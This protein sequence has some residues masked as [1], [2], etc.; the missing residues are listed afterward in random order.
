MII[1]SLVRLYDQLV[2]AGDDSVAPRGYSRQLISFRVVLNKNG[3]LHDIE[4]VVVQTAR[5]IKKKVKGQVVT[6]T[7]YDERPKPMLVPGQ[8]KPSGSG[9]NPCFLWDNAAY[10]LGFKAEDPK[11]ERTKEAFKAFRDRHLALADKIKDDGFKAVCAFLKQW[12]PSDCRGF[13]Q[14]SEITANFGVF[15]LRA[16]SRPIHDRPTVRAW[17]ARNGVETDDGSDQSEASAESLSS[18]TR[19]PIARLHEPRIKPVAGAQSSGA[20]IVSFN[21][22]AFESYG[23][24]QGENAP[25]GT[26]DAFKY[27]TALNRLVSDER[28]RVRMSGD[29]YV[30]WSEGDSKA[31]ADLSLYFSSML[32]DASNPKDDVTL[33]RLQG[34]MQ[35]AAEGGRV[36]DFGDPLRPFYVLGLSPNMAR[37]SIRLWMPS[38]VGEMVKKLA[39]L[40]TDLA[41]GRDF[42]SLVPVELRKDRRSSYMVRAQ[43]ERPVSSSMRRTIASLTRLND[44][45]EPDWDEFDKSGKYNRIQESFLRAGL[46]DAPFPLSALTAAV[47]KMGREGRVEVGRL[48]LVK[49]VL[50]RNG[51]FQ[52]DEYLNKRHSNPAY[53]CGRMLAVI[54]RAQAK[55]IGNTNSTITRSN[56]GAAMTAPGLTIPRLAGLAVRAYFPKIGGARRKFIEDELGALHAQLKDRFPRVLDQY[57]QGF[58]LLGYFQE[59]LWLQATW[60]PLAQLKLRTK[61]HEWVRSK[62]ELAVANCL[63]DMGIR[64][65]YEPQ[66]FLKR[67]RERWPDFVIP[68]SQPADEVYIEYLG[69]GG[70]PEYDARWKEKQ[71]EYYAAGVTPE[72]GP[73]GRLVVIDDR[74]RDSAPDDLAIRRALASLAGK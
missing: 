73:S 57:Q 33:G 55:A 71:T 65:V 54:A 13:R 59:D 64:Y 46:T 23:K 24:S 36:K 35:S 40:H 1:P 15:Q 67:G 25:V 49:A 5:E 45:N 10:M 68:A 21:Q 12:K 51:G 32:D 17:W 20:T 34:F 2:E 37:L 43:A 19:Q 6:E 50:R 70:N 62:G 18:G 56:L 8:A 60:S 69:L 7:K 26:E 14:L 52:V 29:T 11:P 28:H 22:G 66:V 47:G 61:G 41:L 53:H 74:A 38:T 72:G 63:H 44:W 4:P 30:F 58:F 48:S 39:N 9:L 42:P 3:T 31:D 27:C 16:E